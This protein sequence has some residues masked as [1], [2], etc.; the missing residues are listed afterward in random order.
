[1]GLARNMMKLLKPQIILQ[2]IFLKSSIP[3]IVQYLLMYY[4]NSNNLH[5]DITS[6][7]E[8]DL[9]TLRKFF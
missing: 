9:N 5:K 6:I 1:M 3:Y 7:E 2:L 8:S 4:R